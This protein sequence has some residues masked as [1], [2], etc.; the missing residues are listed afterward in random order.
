MTRNCV[1][2]GSFISNDDAYFCLKCYQSHGYFELACS[3]FGHLVRKYQWLL[4]F[5]GLMLVLIG[6][7]LGLDG[8]AVLGLVVFGIAV[9]AR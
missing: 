3:L 9:F 7:W 8:I 4:T 6:L 2:C 5:I 1:M